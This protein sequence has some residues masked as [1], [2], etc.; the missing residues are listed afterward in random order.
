MTGNLHPNSIYLHFPFCRHL[1]NYCD[2]HKKV[3]KSD[4][5]VRDFE[6]LLTSMFDRNDQL[7]KENNLSI[8]E[9]D[10]FYIGGG[11]PSLWGEPGARFLKES[12]KA[13]NWVLSKNGEHTLEVNP[14][15]WTEDGLRAWQDFGM[16]RFSLGIQSLNP[17][18]LKILDRVHNIDDVFDTLKQFQKMSVSFSV[19]F[20]L[21]LPRSHEY[22][23]D[24]ISELE[25]ILSYG[26]EHISLYILTTKD[27]YRFKDDLPDDEFIEDEYLK[28]ANFLI[29]KGFSHY[30]VSNFAKENKFSKHNIKYWKMESVLALGPSATGFIAS[31]NFRYKWKVNSSD[32]QEEILT[33]DEIFLEKI[34]MNLRTNIGLSLSIFPNSSQNEIL[35]SLAVKWQERGI[36]TVK[37]EHVILNSKGFLILD[38]LMDD[39]FNQINF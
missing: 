6:S 11:T 32:F 12:L 26:P 35:N 14:G 20:M 28:V 21:G 15:S 30:E 23:R 4:G 27:N 10:T 36:A 29:A 16:N 1:C 3:P 22:K 18:M 33:P 5:E 19:D 38:F 7:L 31:S 13:R 39:L 8:S 25:E 9:I 2:F 17:N 34:Y 24:I 37:N